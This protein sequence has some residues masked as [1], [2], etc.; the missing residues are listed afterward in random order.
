MIARH[1]RVPAWPAV[2]PGP[3][4]AGYPAWGAIALVGVLFIGCHGCKN[5]GAAGPN[6]EGPAVPAVEPIEAGPTVVHVDDDG[7]SFDVLRGSTVTFELAAKAG[8]GFAWVPTQVDPVVLVAQGGRTSEA[9]SDSPGAPKMDVYRFTAAGS[10]STTVAMSLQ[11]AF[12]SA[13][14]AQALRVTLNV[15]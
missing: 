3:A 15:R 12:G 4:A 13:P 11:R 8:T 6:T 10:G 7:K 5:G 2:P 9:S 1:I 14:P